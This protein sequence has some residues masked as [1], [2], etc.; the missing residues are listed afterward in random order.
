MRMRLW[1]F[2]Q[3]LSVIGLM[4]GPAFAECPGLDA[5]YRLAE[6]PSGVIAE[7]RL[8]PAQD[9]STFTDLDLLLTAPELPVPERMALT[10]SNGFMATYAVS[11]GPAMTDD[12]LA[13]EVF[14]DVAGKLISYSGF[15]PKSDSVAPDAM[16]VTGLA[17]SIY[18]A[19][20]MSPTQATIPGG[21]WYLVCD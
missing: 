10:T 5:R 7:L 6:D 8:V 11:L 21:M 15:L 2:C 18:Y 13:I 9:V 17:Q 12:G 19:T 3:R 4:S 14:T 1:R 20:A 16:F